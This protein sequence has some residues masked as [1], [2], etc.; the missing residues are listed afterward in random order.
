MPRDIDDFYFRD[1]AD[2]N[3]ALAAFNALF[4]RYNQWQVTQARKEHQDLF[5]EPIQP[6]EF[7]YKQQTGPAWDQVTKISQL[8]M[9][10][11]LYVVLACN[12]RLQALGE[13]ELAAREAQMRADYDRYCPVDNLLGAADEEPV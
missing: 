7:Y 1:E 6:G 4:T 5:G 12:P 8:S 11:L 2:F 3:R 10:R 9:E 13:R